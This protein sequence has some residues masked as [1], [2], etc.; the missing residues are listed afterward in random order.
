M[1][2]ALSMDDHYNYLGDESKSITLD[3]IPYI[4]IVN[5]INQTC[6]EM[7]ILAGNA[8]DNDSSSSDSDESI[9]PD[10]PYDGGYRDDRIP[11]TKTVPSWAT[12]IIENYKQNVV[13]YLYLVASTPI[14]D[15]SFRQR[16]YHDEVS[17]RHNVGNSWRNIPCVCP[18][19]NSF[20]G[21]KTRW[22]NVLNCCIVMDRD[23]PKKG[24][25]PFKSMSGFLN[26][27]ASVK[28]WNHTMLYYYLVNLYGYKYTKR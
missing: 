8:F 14:I 16:K 5:A 15:L 19:H 12:A 25:A 28:D 17:S 7:K 2:I 27:C 11:T 10:D 3:L 20:L 21:M 18:F 13:E 24:Q 26:H 6:E 23:C 9:N 1:F 4:D 22:N